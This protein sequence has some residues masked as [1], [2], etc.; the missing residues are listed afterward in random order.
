VKLADII[1]NLEKIAPPQLAYE[2]DRIGLQVGDV[3][4]DV[5][6][7]V[8]AVDPTPAVV[9]FAIESKADLLVTHHPLIFTPLN[10]LAA[11]NIVQDRIIKLIKAGV[12]LYVMHT[13]YDSAPEG[14]NDSLANR[15][16]I[17]VT[18]N[19]R[20]NNCARLFKIVVFT[21]VEAVESVRDA[22]ADAGAG[23]IGNYSHCS[24]RTQGIGTFLPQ[25]G[26][27]PVIGNIGAVQSVEEYRLEMIV[28]ESNLDEVIDAMIKAHPYE[29]VAY[30]IYALENKVSAYGYGRVGNLE[31]PITLGEFENIVR[32]R[33]CSGS[34]RVVGSKD[35]MVQTVGLCGGSA[36]KF[37][38]DA[39][40][41]GVD[42]FLCGEMSYHEMLD[43]DAM[44]LA[45]I[46]AGHYETEKPGM[47]E[48]ANRLDAEYRDAQILVEF[49][50]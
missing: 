18:G 47:E 46:A 43:A 25:P 35:N 2:G 45:V 3:G 9:D 34:L 23:V 37:I 31:N 33:I 10:S 1:H 50:P 26:T 27:N 5:R 49:R 13:N 40:S 21:P 7:I 19:L 15:L 12:A 14:I 22:M 39:K 30:D 38:K 48:L 28:A 29:E 36:G 6:H 41:N 42:V 8:V 11:G 44:G 17:K 16:E 24:F 4:S 20:A 32:D